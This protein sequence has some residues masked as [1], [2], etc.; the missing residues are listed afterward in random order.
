M[1]QTKLAKEY[2]HELTRINKSLTSI[3]IWY[4]GES[5]ELKKIMGI[6]M[7][8]TIFIS[9]NNNVTFYYDSE[10]AEKF[11]NALKK[12]ITD[13]FFNEL[14]DRFFILISEIQKIK[15]KK[16]MFEA[17]SKYFSILSIFDEISKYPEI[18]SDYVIRRLFRVRKNTESQFYN[19]IKSLESSNEPENYIYY[20]NKTYT[21][22]E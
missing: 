3:K 5:K 16:E 7:Y 10:E 18:A 6:G 14:C 1:E 8:N 19:F 11:H 20:K 9:L 17:L 12:T 13:E 22:T 2:Y 15:N 4:A 21:I